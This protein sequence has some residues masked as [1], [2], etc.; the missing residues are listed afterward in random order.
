MEF[1]RFQRNCTKGERSTVGKC[2]REVTDKVFA[3]LSGL[4]VGEIV[5]RFRSTFPFLFLRE[6]HLV[7]ASKSLRHDFQK[8]IV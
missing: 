3:S 6:P 5:D 2:P 4:E 1:C 7:K 8:T